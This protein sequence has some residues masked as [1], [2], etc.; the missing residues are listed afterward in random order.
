MANEVF[1][2]AKGRVNEYMR[3]VDTNDPTNS[4]IVVILLEAAEADATLRDYDDLG[5]LLGAAGN[6]EAADA[7][8]VRKILDDTNITAPTPDDTADDQASDLPDITWTA[9]AGNAIV[10]LIVCYDPDTTA[11]TDADII[12]LT[13]HDFS[14]T[15]DG[16]DVTAQITDFFTAT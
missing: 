1:N 3:R 15:P 13:H 12:P 5:A 6:T 2:I 14:V 7:S 10:K 9:L 11:G 4:A 16:S 8:Y